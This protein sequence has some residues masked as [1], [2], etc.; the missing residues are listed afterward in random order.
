MT[1]FAVAD[2]DAAAAQAAELGGSVVAEPFD[3]PTVGRFAVLRDPVGA[4]FGVLAG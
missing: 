3:I 1:I 4:G 2:C